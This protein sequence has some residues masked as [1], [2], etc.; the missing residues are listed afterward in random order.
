MED[1]FDK[2]KQNFRNGSVLTKLIFVNVAVFVFLRV[3]D[4]L[5]LLFNLREYS[6]IDWLQM[7]SYPPL[8]ASKP[9]TVFTYMFT[10]WGFLHI[11]FN[12]LVL[13]W[14][15]RIFMEFFTPRQLGGLYIEGGLG[16]AL[17][18]LLAYNLLP[19][20]KG[21]SEISTLVGASAAVMAIVF[22]AAFYHKD[23]EIGIL[24]LGRVKLIYLALGIFLVDILS[25][26]SNNA[27]GHLAH[28]GGALVGIWFASSLRKGRDLTSPIAF[29]LDKIANL[30]RRKRPKMRVRPGGRHTETKYEYNARRNA[31]N[32]EIDDILDKLKRSGYDSLSAEEKRKLFDASRK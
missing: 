1:L 9:W 24:F 4:V 6:P 2:L 3:A 32:K 7:P 15:G 17:L 23:Y 14:F 18:F 13:Y 30:F 27:G 8:L 20:Y 21:M 11:L 31:E 12:M 19:Y 29:L 10:H 25:I 26:A 22:A 28:L 5:L 16:G